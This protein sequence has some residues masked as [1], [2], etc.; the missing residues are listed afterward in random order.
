MEAPLPQ[1]RT[2][3]Q[4]DDYEVVGRVGPIELSSPPVRVEARQELLVI[5][6]GEI[7]LCTRRDGDVC[8]GMV[9]G[10]GLYMDDTRFLS[11]LQ[12]NVGGVAPV[13]LSSVADGRFAAIVDSTNPELKV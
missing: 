5:K 7:F 2:G 12:L 1:T 10:E 11:E 8:P 4:G 13:L 3:P 6:N 9:S